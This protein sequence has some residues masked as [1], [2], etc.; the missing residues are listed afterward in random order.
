MEHQRKAAIL[1]K[2]ASASGWLSLGGK[3]LRGLKKGVA[4]GKPD[5]AAFHSAMDKADDAWRKM[6]R[7]QKAALKKKQGD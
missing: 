2:L 1:E 3:A 5:W 7:A 4:S 6:S